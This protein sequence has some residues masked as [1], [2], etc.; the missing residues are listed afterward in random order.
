MTNY[1]KLALF[2]FLLIFCE[3][4][5]S[6]QTLA[7]T[8]TASATKTTTT[9]VK[10]SPSPTPSPQ[11]SPTSE[12]TTQNLK[13]RIEKVV[14][15]RRE[16]LQGTLD[17]LSQKKR[18]FI[19]QVTRISEGTIT[20][21]NSKGSQVIPVAEDVSI[22]KKGKKIALSEISVDDWVILMGYGNSDN[23]QLK[24]IVASSESLRPSNHIVILGSIKS[25]T[26]KEVKILPRNQ[27]DETTAIINKKT[28]FQTYDGKSIK[29]KEVQTDA[30]AFL[31][32]TVT[33]DGTTANLIRSLSAPINEK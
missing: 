30:Q 6:S 17:Q 9:S 25:L 16:Q 10:A 28:R 15:E 2:S 4:G 20:V 3:L 24:R 32:G 12:T 22:S 1:L 27:N 29:A 7:L 11:A 26:D 14:Q 31:I 5:L 33:A 21:K 23:F 8:S 13:D 19:G 18:G